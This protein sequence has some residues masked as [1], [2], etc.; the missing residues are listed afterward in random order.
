M[1]TAPTPVPSGHASQ[2]ITVVLLAA[3]VV[4][5]AAAVVLLARHDWGGSSSSSAI[6]GSG[7]AA[8][9]TREVRAFSAVDLAGGNNVT[10]RVGGRQSVVV[11]AD[12]NLIDLVTTSVH[13]GSLT[14]GARGNFS[15]K[16]PLS[17]EVT[18]PSLD[19]VRLSGS[20]AVT[21]EGVRAERF[22]VDVPGSGLVRVTGT[23]GRLDATLAGSGDVQLQ[24]LVARDVTAVVSGSGRLQVR[25]TRSLDATVS[26]TG[27]I[28][29]S[30]NPRNLTQKV[31]GT[32]IVVRQ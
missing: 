2:R 1:S 21:V 20:G 18:V 17:V 29:Y 8:T 27:A 19:A 31:T 30:G 24:E 7:I 13:G 16:G 6:R 4:L 3:L 14:I 22:A 32:G 10:V 11:H 12:D 26:G 25:A 15:T 9:Q 28:V 5:V 23:T